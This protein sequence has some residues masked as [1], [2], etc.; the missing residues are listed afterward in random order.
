[1]GLIHAAMSAQHSVSQQ[2]AAADG[3]TRTGCSL[4]EP[5]WE[6]RVP[7]ARTCPAPIGHGPG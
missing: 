5:T 2:P 6:P 4:P 1:V 3:E 7:Q